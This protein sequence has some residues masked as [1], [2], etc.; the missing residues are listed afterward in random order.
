M[1]A[2]E[3][4]DT[5]L[6]NGI[7][8]LVDEHPF[9]AFILM[10]TGIEFLGKCL[11]EGEWDTSNQSRDDFNA[12]LDK[13]DSL[14]KYKEIEN[15][16]NKLR[17]GLAHLGIPKTGLTL[18]PDKNN[19]EANPILLGCKEFYEDFKAACTEITTDPKS[20]VKKKMDE[21]YASIIGGFT[22]STVSNQ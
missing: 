14:G 6:I 12:A 18:C 15:L 1:N 3:Y 7:G 21:D 16:Y 11:N 20:Q 10:A 22:S 13:L 2:R 8:R 17:C 9:Q 4:I 19:L 5:F